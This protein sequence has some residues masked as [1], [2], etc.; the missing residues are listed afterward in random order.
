MTKINQSQ[1][2]INSRSNSTK[3]VANIPASASS[4]NQLTSSPLNKARNRTAS[5]YGASPKVTSSRVV[6][7][8]AT[9][10]EV[11]GLQARSAEQA[12]ELVNIQK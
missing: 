9:T 12:R 7:E 3:G 6:S 2:T 4:R 5:K 8:K 11:A 1:S 10:G